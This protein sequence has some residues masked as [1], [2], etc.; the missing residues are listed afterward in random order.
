[1]III[2]NK[3]KTKKEN[4]KLKIENWKLKKKI[5]KIKFLY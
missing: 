1:M 2:N 3:Y 5:K 4:R